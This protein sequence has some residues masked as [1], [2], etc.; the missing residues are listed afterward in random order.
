MRKQMFISAFLSALMLS[1]FGQEPQAVAIKIL[2]LDSITE[3]GK[4]DGNG[5]SV[6]IGKD[7]GSIVSD[8]GKVELIF[9]PGALNKKKKITIQA[10]ANHAANGRGKAYLMKPSGI[11]FEKPVTLVFSYDDDELSGTL[12]ELK[13]IAMQD[14]HGKWEN[15]SMI[16]VDTIAKTITTQIHHFSSY[17]SFDKMVLLPATARVKV[18]KSRLLTI[19]FV[20]TAHSSNAGDDELP[21]LP[22]PI[23][24]PQWSV[25]GI[26]GGNNFVGRISA[27]A[28]NAAL[29]T[30]PAGIPPENPVAISARLKGLEFK[31]NN[32]VFKDPVLVSHLLVY[33]KAYRVQMKMWVDNSEDGACTMRIEDGGEF[34]LVME[35][36]AA[37]IKEIRNQHMTIRFNSCY[38]GMTWSNQPLSRKGPIQILGARRLQI[39]PASLPDRP[40][41]HVMIFLQHAVAMMPEFDISCPGKTPMKPTGMMPMLPPLLEFDAD[42]REEQV[43]TLAD[44]TKGYMKNGSRHG[45]QIK[46]TRIDTE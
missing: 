45:V 1:G 15:L 9:P 36:T 42:N 30:A 29:F 7:G 6:E 32:H 17:A 5:V 20:T 44:L 27:Q 16:T 13:G 33:D 31:F 26:A 43:L 22:P 18:E 39:T 25:N 35:G 23:P 8:D 46:I 21:P 24:A 41:P 10:A 11:R 38:C 12:P 19:Q 3:V 2:R 40:F 34:T 4:P 37:N 14:D 28:G